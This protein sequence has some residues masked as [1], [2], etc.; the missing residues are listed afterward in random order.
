MNVKVAGV[1]LSVSLSGTLWSG[2]AW[3][4]TPREPDTPLDQ[5]AF[6]RPELYV[7]SSHA[8]LEELLPQMRNRPVWEAF[9]VQART[10]PL[11]SGSRVF[12][13]P[14]SGAVTNLMGPFPIIPGDGAGNHVTLN[15]L[16]RRLG[17]PIRH[18]DGQVVG[19]AVRQ[20]VESR[21]DLLAID[22]RQ[23]GE[24]LATQVNPDLWQLSF[25]QQHGGVRVRDARVAATISHGNLVLVGTETWGDV[26]GLQTTPHV[27]AEDAVEAGFAYAGGRASQDVIVRE[28]G[29]EIVPL[30]PPEYQHGDAYGGPV[31]EGYRHRLVWTFVFQRPPE[32]PRWEVMVDAHSGEVIAFQDINQY[33]QGQVKGGVYP[34]TS[35]GVCPTVSTCG[36][37]Q[38]GWPTPFV[39]TGLAAPNDFANSAG[40][41]DYP[42]GTVTTTLTGKYVDIVDACGAISASASTGSLDLGG[43]NGQHDCTSAG[44]SPGNTSASRTAYYEVNKIAEMARGWLPSN[45]WLQ[46]RLTT[47]VNLNYTCNAY[48]DGASINFFRSG[49][50]CRNTG[51]IDGVFD[52]EW[53]HGLDQNDA[54]RALSNSSEAYADIAAIDRLQ[55]SC[56]GHGFWW[57]S[58]QGCG[59][60]SDGTGYNAN[61]AQ[62]GASHC[63]IDCSGVRDADWNMHADHQPDTALGFVCSSC[64][65]GT[66]PCGRQ[67]H[68]AAAPSRQAA[69]DLAARDLQAAPFSYDGQTAFIIANKIFYQGSGNIGLW[70][71]C[72]CG[73]SSSGC[74]ATNAYMQWLAADDDDGNLNHGTPHMTALYNAFNRHGIACSAPTPQNSGCGEGPTAAPGL[75]VTPGGSGLDLSW[76]A[77]AGATRYWVFRSEG[78]AG[79]RF[80]KA[81]VA[82]VTG[83][84]YTDTQVAGGRGYSYNVVAAGPASACFGPASACVTV[85]TGNPFVYASSTDQFRACYGIASSANSSYCS[86]ISDFNDSQ[87]C[88][89]LSLGSQDPCRSITDRNLQLACYGMATRYW[90]THY[91]SNC[92]DITD[93]NMKNFCYGVSSRDYTYCEPVGDRDTQL[94]CYAMSDEISSNCRDISDP[95][96][97]NF[98]YGVS[99]HDTS[100]CDQISYP[101]PFTV[102]ATAPSYITVKDTYPL[103][104]AASDPASDWLW[105]RSD[106]GSPWQFWS[107]SQNSAFVAYAGT[108]TI[109]WRLSARRN[110]DGAVSYGYATTQV[111]IGSTNC[112]PYD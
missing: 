40:V 34:L 64:A 75:T 95:N 23:L 94:Q 76:T 74:G 101:H 12:V 10:D 99:S 52:H 38:S 108:Y 89:G 105:E 71:A 17:G 77:V 32:E 43:L 98:C 57:T 2:P 107:N 109:E 28:P 15:D 81:L 33:E 68:C 50:G 4:A 70:H 21:R 35:T 96:M 63:D 72:T 9:L 49:G 85:P 6:F 67:V 78:S 83:T 65:S 24:P 39:D 16:S 3:T 100:Y 27:K 29:I 82:E 59:Q 88:L 79:C 69:W 62:V 111:C 48:W 26:R 91:P 44:Y 60:T 7:S 19:T 58:N 86:G 14:R 55:T 45:T 18:V 80:G 84:A 42:G 13:D 93:Q 37:M 97:R 1:V 90:S 112:H 61:E 47:N 30:A 36:R 20:F 8:P 11:R 41:F 104:G 25:P 87:M 51:E 54:G 103:T 22:T 5:K 53:G 73:S 31:G 102:S 92:R 106:D 110:S 56:V 46:S 66:G